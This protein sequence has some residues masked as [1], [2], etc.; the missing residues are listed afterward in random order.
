[1]SKVVA[2]ILCIC[3]LWLGISN[4]P[5]NIFSWDVFG[6]YLYLPLTFI[7][8]DLGIRDVS[9]VNEIIEKYHNTGTFYQAL[10]AGDTGN[11]IM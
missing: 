10:P 1:M 5:L 3:L 7:Y 6:Y 2:G 11:M 8:H 9:I 4:F